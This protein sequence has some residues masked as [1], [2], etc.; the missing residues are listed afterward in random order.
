[1]LAK[2]VAPLMSKGLLSVASASVADVGGGVFVA[3]DT[4]GVAAGADVEARRACAASEMTDPWKIRPVERA[5][6][7]ARGLAGVDI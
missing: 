6:S 4:A 7:A 5:L 2:S 1:M 3:A